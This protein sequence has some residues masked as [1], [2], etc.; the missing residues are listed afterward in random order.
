LYD[1]DTGFVR[2]GARD[3]DASVGRWTAK[4]PIRW[5]GGQSNVY[6]YVDAD[7]LNRIDPN[8]NFALVICGA[9]IGLLEVLT[10]GAVTAAAGIGA[11]T[12]DRAID[13]LLDWY[14][15]TEQAQLDHWSKQLGIPRRDLGKAIH[16]VKEAANLRPNENVTIKPDGTVIDN[17]TGNEIGNIFDEL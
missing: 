1:A 9:G 2:F 15:K 16:K 12:I 4:D 3:Y 6:L 8:G 13:R 5:S 11:L 14:S 17:A 10:A 7:P